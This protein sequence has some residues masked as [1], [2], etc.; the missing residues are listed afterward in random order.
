[1][2]QGQDQVTLQKFP[3][4]ADVRPGRQGARA[5]LHALHIIVLPASLGS[6][7]GRRGQARAA[8][9]CIAKIIAVVSSLPP[10]TWYNVILHGNTTSGLQV[11][12]RD[13]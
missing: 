9:L 1:M 5:E 3:T 13:R 10:R 11:P 2:R 4:S 6:S 8:P 7:A 12:D